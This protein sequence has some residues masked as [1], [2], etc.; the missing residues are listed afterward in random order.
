[1]LKVPFDPD[2]EPVLQNYVAIQLDEGCA[3]HYRR[4]TSSRPCQRGRIIGAGGGI[5]RGRELPSLALRVAE[6]GAAAKIELKSNHRVRPDGPK[7]SGTGSNV[8]ANFPKSF[9]SGA[10]SNS[11]DRI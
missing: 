10:G 9:G 11:T 3:F 1:M 4:G 6:T 7:D 8:S 5:L 2:E